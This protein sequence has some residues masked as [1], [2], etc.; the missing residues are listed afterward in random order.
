MSSG[1]RRERERERASYLSIDI[2]I[3][4]G[5]FRPHVDDDSGVDHRLRKEVERESEGEVY[6]KEEKGLQERQRSPGEE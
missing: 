5:C 4:R 1:D 3:I 6:E 2:R